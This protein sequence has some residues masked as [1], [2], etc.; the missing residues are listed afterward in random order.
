MIF[1]NTAVTGQATRLRLRSRS[2]T[3]VHILSLQATW[4]RNSILNALRN[5]TK[6]N[7]RGISVDFV[8]QNTTILALG[9]FIHE[10]ASAGVSRQSDG[11]V[12]GMKCLVDKYAKDF[13]TRKPAG[14]VTLQEDTILVTG[15]TGAIGSATLAEL[16]K[17]SNV[18]RVVVL[19]RKSTTPI[20]VRQRKA[21]EDRDLDPSIIDSTKI[22][23][24]EGDPGLPGF[25]L[26][27]NILLELRSIITCILHIGMPEKGF[28]VHELT[29]NLSL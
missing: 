6:L 4:I 24:L 22:I 15:T 7:T 8:Y 18:V 11:A 19:A 17:S 29:S 21:L 28:G 9:K 12:E 25:G 13:P 27:D 16:Y 26:D 3:G 1:S 2:L 5:T 20:S 14:G 10:F 23:L